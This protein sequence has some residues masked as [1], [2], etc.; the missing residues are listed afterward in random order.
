MSGITP[1]LGRI[2]QIESRFTPGADAPARALGVTETRG[3]SGVSVSALGRESNASRFDLVMA[4]AESTL[5]HEV[6]ASNTGMPPGLEFISAGGTTPWTPVASDD[7][8]DGHDD[9]HN[10]AH[11]PAQIAAYQEILAAEPTAGDVTGAQRAA[12]I[13]RVGDTVPAGTPF[14]D[15]FTEAAGAHGVPPALLAAVG[16][17]ESGYDVG[18]LSP[19]GAIGVMQLMPSDAAELGVDP[20]DPASA[21]EGAA[22]LLSG[23]EDR[24]GSWEI[25]LAAYFSGPGAVSRNAGQAPPGGAA[26]AHRVFER[27]ETA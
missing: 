8:H 24:F 4:A 21:I 3:S 27:M 10:H 16:W 26:Y 1:I 12:T 9:G 14:A 11:D 6:L 19:D 5:D 23:Y 2:A 25:A 18:A 20:H 13:A 17:V 22:R 7:H 15:I